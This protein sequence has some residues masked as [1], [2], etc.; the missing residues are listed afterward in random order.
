MDAQR[1]ANVQNLR[2]LRHQDQALRTTATTIPKHLL[3]PPPVATPTP[4]GIVNLGNTCY[5]NATIQCLKH[6]VPFIRYFFDGRFDNDRLGMINQRPMEQAFLGHY[7]NLMKNLIELPGAAKPYELLKL[8]YVLNKT[9]APGVQCDAQECLT[10]ILDTL[11]IA[12]RINVKITV[13][14]GN[15]SS[16][17]YNRMVKSYRQY[18][19]YLKHGGYSAINEIF[20]SQF[21][22]KLT[23]HLCNHESNSYDPYNLIPIEIAQKAISLYDCLDQFMHAEDL[24]N[25]QCEHCKQKTRATKQFRL[26]TLP[27]MLIIQLKRFDPLMRKTNQ[28]IQSPLILNLTKYVSFPRVVSNI[29]DNP[30]ALQLYDLKGIICHA[31]QLHGG[32]YTAKCYNTGSDTVKPGWYDFNDERVTYIPDSQLEQTLQSP[33]NYILFYEMSPATKLFWKKFKNIK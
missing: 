13:D 30:A 27:Q 16:A 1:R 20:G 5:F 9:F 3:N 8:L 19:S 23:C 2:R 25:V 21:E 31:G 4:P 29:Q 18:E 24:D 12:L 28:H 33:L 17:A 6:S 15:G 14:N 7:Y 32:H 22:S 10:T 11:H 26:W